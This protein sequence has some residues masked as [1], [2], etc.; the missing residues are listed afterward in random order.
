VFKHCRLNCTLA[1]GS[2]FI[3]LLLAAYKEMQV[4]HFSKCGMNIGTELLTTCMSFE[5]K[6]VV[7]Q[8]KLHETRTK[9]CKKRIS[10]PQITQ[11]ATQKKVKSQIQMCFSGLMLAVLSC[12]KLSMMFLKH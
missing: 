6:D 8:K 2:F 4:P 1:A 10:K 9:P 5:T 3:Q 7:H 11:S 12:P